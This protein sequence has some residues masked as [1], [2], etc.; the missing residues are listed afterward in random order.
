MSDLGCF[1]HA[2]GIRPRQEKK[3]LFTTKYDECKW[4]MVKRDVR[5]Y[6]LLFLKKT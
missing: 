4:G 3:G 2:I 6:Q 1:N 5:K